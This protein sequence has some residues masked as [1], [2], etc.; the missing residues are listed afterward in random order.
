MLLVIADGVGAL[1]DVERQVGDEPPG[2]GKVREQVLEQALDAGE[3]SLQPGVRERLGVD[4]EA[5][6]Y[7]TP[8]R[9]AMAARASRKS[10]R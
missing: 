3:E 7:I 9:N 6:E 1:L 2:L 10:R 5:I 4:D 8:M